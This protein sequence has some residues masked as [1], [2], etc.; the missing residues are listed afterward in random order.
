MCQRAASRRMQT[1]VQ[2]RH[3]CE[4]KKKKPADAA[5]DFVPFL[6][7]RDFRQL[8]QLSQSAS[9]VQGLLPCT[10]SLSIKY[11]AGLYIIAIL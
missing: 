3:R 6:C 4:R 2:N 11:F 8:S 10:V 9:Q 7:D 1:P 5:A